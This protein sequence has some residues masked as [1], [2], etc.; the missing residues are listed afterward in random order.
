MKIKSGKKVNIKKDED[1]KEKKKLS[2]KEDEI[3][4]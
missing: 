1:K 4:E 2:K 3:Q